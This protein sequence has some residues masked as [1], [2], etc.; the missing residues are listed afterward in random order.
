MRCSGKWKVVKTW[1]GIDALGDARHVACSILTDA[2]ADRDSTS[3]LWMPSRSASSGWISSQSES[4]MLDV[5]RSARHRAGVVVLEPAA[6]DED[7]RELL[8]GMVARLLVGERGELAE[9]A[10]QRE[11]GLVQDRRVGA[12]SGCTGHCR[13]VRPSAVR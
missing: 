10:W 8:V 6:G 2:A 11:G 3:P 12:V 4:S 7:Q 1:P 5:V 9:A 13:P